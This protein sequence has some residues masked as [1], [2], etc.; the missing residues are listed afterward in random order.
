MEAINAALNK[1]SRDLMSDM[2]ISLNA[3]YSELGL[4]Q[5]KMGDMIGWHIDWGL[6]EP[7]F[8]T[9]ISEDGRPCL[10]LDYRIEPKYSDR[11]Y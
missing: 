11:G 3:V 4:E 7:D 10:V 9:Q 8:D 5:T 2:Y 1:L 6:I